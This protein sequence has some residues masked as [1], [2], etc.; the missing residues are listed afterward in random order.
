MYALCYPTTRHDA[1]TSSSGRTSLPSVL[2]LTHRLSNDVAS[3]PSVGRNIW[4]YEQKSGQKV[5]TRLPNGYG[6]ARIKVLEAANIKTS[7]LSKWEAAFFPSRKLADGKRSRSDGTLTMTLPS[8]FF[9]GNVPIPNLSRNA[10]TLIKTV[11]ESRRVKPT[12]DQHDLRL[13]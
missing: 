5:S 8:A 10:H 11:S 1:D 4:V 7:E 13:Q 3:S 12:P 2:M 9:Y 6:R